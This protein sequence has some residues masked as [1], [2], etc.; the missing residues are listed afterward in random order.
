MAPP[1]AP[2]QPLPWPIF[3]RI[4]AALAAVELTV[5]VPVALDVVEFKVTVCAEVQVGTSVAPVGL[6]V[7]LQFS[8]TVPEYPL[9]V[10]T[11]TV[12]LPLPPGDN[13]SA[14]AVIVYAA[15][16]TVMEAVPAAVL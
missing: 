12:E 11:D 7:T 13:V 15:L 5:T 2:A 3:G 16:V 10:L 14:V 4:N 9:V 1:S 8:V 6:A